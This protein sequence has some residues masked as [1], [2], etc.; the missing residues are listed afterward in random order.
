MSP[1]DEL[2][3]HLLEAERILATE[4]SFDLAEPC[5]LRCLE[6]V[7]ANPDQRVAFAAALTEA[8]DQGLICDEPVAY[9]MHVL[10]WSEVRTWAESCLRAMAH[11]I[12]DG[13]PLEKI[14]EAYA[15]DWGHREF[16]PSLLGMPL[17]GRG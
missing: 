17:S 1:I 15:A 5:Y 8:F 16:Y 4:F 12:A 3:S 14:I 10:E 13:R 9:L 7:R 6:I 11:P 2:R